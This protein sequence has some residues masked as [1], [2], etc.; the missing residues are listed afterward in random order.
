V[1][2]GPY[3]L[4]AVSDSGAGVD[5]STREKIFEP[6]LTTKGLIAGTGLALSTVYGI[7]KQSDGHIEVY[8]EINRGTTFEIYL[9]QA[10]D[11][12][13]RTSSIPIGAQ[14]SGPAV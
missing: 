6:F 2:P 13:D 5:E 7:V 11:V 3:V 4:L 8:S 1:Q 12:E 14:A 10:V 9:P